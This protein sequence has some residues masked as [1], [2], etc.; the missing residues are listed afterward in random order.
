MCGL[1]GIAGTIH[2]SHDKVFKQLLYVD[3]LRGMH[4]TGVLFVPWL[5]NSPPKV[6]KSAL[7]PNDFLTRLDVIGSLTKK[8]IVLLGHNRYATVGKVTDENAHPFS[9]DNVIG[10]HNGTL[11]NKK[12]LPDDKEFT[13]DSENLYHSIDKLG[14][15][16]TYEIIQGAWALSWW[17]KEAGTLN[18]IRNYQRPLAYTFSEDRKTMFWASE[19]GM[20]E[21]LLERNYVKHTEIV[22]TKPHHRYTFEIPTDGKAISNIIIKDMTP[23]P[24]KISYVKKNRGSSSGFSEKYTNKYARKRKEFV[25]GNLLTNK[26]NQSYFEGEFIEAPYEKVNLYVPPSMNYLANMYSAGELFIGTVTHYNK[27]EDSYYISPNNLEEIDLVDVTNYHTGYE[28]E[29]LT[30]PQ[31]KS[32]VPVGCAWCGDPVFFDDDLLWIASNDIMCE[33]CGCSPDTE[34]YRKDIGVH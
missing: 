9:F 2:G 10:A 21:Y 30:L 31:F 4:S 19:S 15:E 25:L 16:D 1:V 28:G 34:V 24:K 18:F 6:L 14:L 20:L 33:D 8:N 29:Q 22:E 17:D 7:P 23:K 11:T 12:S 32:R 26:Y 5:K 27:M 13:V 3:G